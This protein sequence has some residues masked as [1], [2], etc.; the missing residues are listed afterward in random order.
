MKVYQSGIDRNVRGA[1]KL[2]KSLDSLILRVDQRKARGII[3]RE[4]E[5]KKQMNML[6]QQGRSML[7]HKSDS[8][9]KY[10]VPANV[11][12]G[13]QA[14]SGISS[15]IPFGNDRPSIAKPE[16]SF[17]VFRDEPSTSSSLTS[18]PPSSRNDP[19]GHIFKPTRSKIDKAENR[20]TAADF[21][22]VTIPQSE[23]KE[24]VHE[25]FVIFRDDMEPEPK[26]RPTRQ[27]SGMN[28]GSSS[29]DFSITETSLSN[30]S[31]PQTRLRIE[32]E[33]SK[34]MEKHFRQNEEKYFESQNTKG[35]MEIITVLKATHTR[36]CFEEDRIFYKGIKYEKPTHSQGEGKILYI[37][38]YV[39]V[40]N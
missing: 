11:R 30:S 35:Q 38:I 23:V 14:A 1:K 17:T 29:D 37:Y 27:H 19:T 16:P 22:G 2:Q 32:K 9:S 21:V 20:R 40:E 34:R 15:R 7:G 13:I 3:T 31:I 36:A 24:T 26:K 28:P 10:S 25:P 5:A 6:K 33:H 4:S 18:P 39:R 8:R 12:A